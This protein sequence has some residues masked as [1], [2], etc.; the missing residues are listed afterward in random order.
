M[1]CQTAAN[2][3]LGQSCGLCLFLSFIEDTAPLLCK[4]VTLI[5]LLTLPHPHPL[6]VILQLLQKELLKIQQCYLGGWISYQTLAK[7]TVL[8]LYSYTV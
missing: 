6:L 5:W 8:V 7:T 4:G 2:E 1:G 3:C